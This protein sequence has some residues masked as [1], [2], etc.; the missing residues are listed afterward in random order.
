MNN[1]LIKVINIIKP[2][3]KVLPVLE[4]V[5]FHKGKMTVTDLFTTVVLN[6]SL[7]PSI[8]CLVDANI[9]VKS[10]LKWED[11]SA[12]LSDREL[13]ISDGIKECKFPNVSIDDFPKTTDL[14][15]AE[16]IGILNS[17]DISK[18]ISASK[19]VSRDEL[20]PALTKVAIINGFIVATDAHI[21]RW[22]ESDFKSDNPI[23]IGEKVCRLLS[24]FSGKQFKLYTTKDGKI[25][26]DAPGVSIISRDCF[27]TF[28]EFGKV[29][30]EAHNTSVFVGRETLVNTLEEA[31]CFS[32]SCTNKVV[33]TINGTLKVSSYNYDHG[34][35]FNKSISAKKE[36]DD[37]RIGF[38]SKL[39]IKAIKSIKGDRMVMRFQ[40]PSKAVVI[41]DEILVMP[42]MLGEED[43]I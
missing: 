36:G 32:D 3:S 11:I 28:P 10:F 8:S 22:V 30:P 29:I 37:I 34:I 7:D 26:F 27:E 15:E 13:I 16:F 2:G 5:M 31:L 43:S 24:I 35:S 33:L 19:F 42:V 41:N 23:L 6:S 40:D 14:N 20:R 1:K 21:M 38:N 4:M 25:I 17:E 12:N 39:L 18:I 9:A